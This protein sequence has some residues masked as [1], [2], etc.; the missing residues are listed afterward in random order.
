MMRALPL[1][2]LLALGPA[3]V[4][5]SG[6]GGVDA[7]IAELLRL[8]QKREPKCYAT[9]SR[10]E[11]FMY[12]TPLSKE[13]RFAKNLLQKQ[14]IEWV[15]RRAGEAAR[16]DGAELVEARHVEAVLADVLRVTAEPDGHFAVALNGRPMRINGV[17]KRQYGSVAYS[18]R[19][20]LA[21]Q[22]E[23]LLGS[24]DD[25]VFL[26]EHAVARLA[27]ALDF[28]TLAALKLTDERMRLANLREV[29]RQPLV[30]NWLALTGQP[31]MDAG[32][33]ASP[34]IDPKAVAATPADLSLL[35]AMIGQKLAS[36]AAYNNVSN[37]LFMRNLQVYFARSRWPSDAQAGDA[38]RR[39]FTESMIAFTR[40]LYLGAEREALAA[41]NPSIR[42]ADVSH[43]AE[44][45]I[46]HRINEYEDA[47][48]FP[49]LPRAEQIEIESYDMD[50]FRDPGWHWRYLEAAI[51]TE[52]FAPRLQLDPFAA[53]LLTENVAQFGVLILRATGDLA[54][55]R[56]KEEVSVELLQA[57]FKDLQ[58]RINRHASA[59]EEPLEVEAIAS[60]EGDSG[61]AGRFVEIT[62]ASGI[63]YQ[64]RNSD[65][66]SR[67]LRSFLRRDE[68]TGVI[69]IPPAFGGGGV[70]AGDINNDGRDD[71]LLL[72][73]RGAKLYL[74]LG[75]GTFRD[76]TDTA[77]IDW[78]REDSNQPGEMRQPLIA[79]FDND[80]LQDI[81]ITYVDD[82]HRL[83]RNRGEL[84]F[85]DVTERSGLGGKG[86]V[87]GPATTFDYDNDG[88]LDVYI[89]NFGDYLGG[90]LPTLARRNFNGQPD[91]LFRNLGDFRFEDVTE[92]AGVADS[93]WGQ[94]T[95]H[96]DLDGDG[97]QD[98]ISGNDFGIN[99]YYL[100][101]GDGS[102]VDAAA[103]LGTD[104]PSFTMS[105]GITD[106]NR[107]R[108]PDIY[109]ANIVTMNKDETYVMPTKDTPA[110]FDPEK[111]KAMRVVEANDLFVSGR[112]GKAL[113]Y[114]HSDAIGRGHSS[115]GWSWDADFFDA[116]NDGDDDLYVLNG[117]NEYNVYSR[118]NP[119][120]T[121]PFED[122]Q[123][124][125]AF[126]DAGRAAN[127]YFENRKG[128]LEN[129]SEGSGLDF[130]GNSR[131]A[132]YLDIDGDG[133]L[134]IVTLDYQGPARVFRNEAQQNG[135]QW[136][137]VRLVGAPARK[138]NRDAI[139]ARLIATA[140]GLQVFREVRGSEGYMS[141]HPRTQHFGLGKRDKAD[142]EIR[143]PDG[144]TQTLKGLEAGRVH[145]IAY[146][147]EAHAA[148]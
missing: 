65:W 84:R 103:E 47:I 63:D 139:G 85:E 106:L 38:F 32:P 16:K 99:R 131:S 42:E 30:E 19:A 97:D 111:L 72:G 56:G 107:D 121:D 91:R 118:D 148:P 7:V 44:G 93:G 77:G 34:A 116:D 41:G 62:A 71:L 23:W 101:Q 122:R 83:Y 37:Q 6:D 64:H 147:Q 144:S 141:V 70:A 49:R 142:V 115:T 66:L 3:P 125:V 25:V 74:N 98:L 55:E 24:D 5:S 129:A 21:V 135:H 128:R 80:G 4:L 119:Y 126:P 113:R 105:I 146:P 143:W 140:G 117:M 52:G 50:A 79:D 92:K 130:I 100:N 17:D 75:D 132:V 68:G 31:A 27:E 127:V 46:P 8:E 120:Y 88:L 53:E 9:A 95:S 40:D 145:V 48:F 13:A 134:D 86:L 114:Q 36:Y 102:F 94:A 1:A 39:A 78:R 58:A 76:V 43:F 28:V 123:Q 104:K 45:F 82:A 35:R 112:R 12:G 87:G 69:T 51:D 20:I 29:E 109:I 59:S 33:G 10:L 96:T 110:K 26:S 2:L 54:R 90:T 137:G 60:A 14:W 124:A 136:L 67:Q 15:W 11:D 57:A 133:D 18:L 108:T 81:L 89:Q 73:G 22:Q 138:V 61:G